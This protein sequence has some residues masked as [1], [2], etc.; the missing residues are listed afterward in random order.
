MASFSLALTLAGALSALQGPQPF[1]PRP[2]SPFE[3][4]KT[5]ALLRDR[6]PCLGCHQLQ[7]VGGR[8]GPD[9]TEVR[10]RRSPA[11]VYAMITDPQRMS[12]G[13]VMPLVPMPR[14]AAEQLA[15]Y[16]LQGTGPG[17]SEPLRRPGPATGLPEGDAGALYG[18]FCAACH[19]ATGRGD[20]ANA[21]YL[22]VRPAAHASAAEMSRRSD[23]AL[24]DTIFAGGLVMNRS[25]L[26]PPYGRTLARSQIW[27]LVRHIRSL[28]RCDGPAW[29]RENR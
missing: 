23:D 26:M 2:L 8:I 24:F 5:A 11:F 19:G 25:N 7:D 12:P 22:P 6:Y 18:R 4:A 14:G 17:P 29:S 13:T 3:R 10:S 9:L 21:A 28:C 15:S 1:T 27:A 16:L 20:G